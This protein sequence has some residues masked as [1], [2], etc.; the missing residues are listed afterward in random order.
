MSI[1]ILTPKQVRLQALLNK[2]TGKVTL[3]MTGTNVHKDAIFKN[4]GYCLF[5]RQ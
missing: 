3:G 1:V 5:S 4:I 2:E